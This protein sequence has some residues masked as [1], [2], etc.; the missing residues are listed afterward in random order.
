MQRDLLIQLLNRCRDAGFGLTVEGEIWSWNRAAEQLFGYAAKE[1]IGRPFADLLHAR[2]LMDEPIDEHYCRVAVRQGG[3]ASFDMQV[4]PRSGEPLWVSATVLVFEALRASPPVIVHLAHDIT[5]SKHREGLAEQLM[6]T[7]RRVLT[8][9]DEGGHFVPVTPLSEQERRILR[10]FFDGNSA[11]DV[12]EMLG[13]TPQTLRNH[14]HHI[15]QKLGTHNRLEAV[16][17][18]VRRKL[19]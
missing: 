8:V 14:L 6:E 10:G 1:A 12:T 19:I 9:T 5:V 7:A 4:K 3:V 13:I 2:G 11:R 18:A 17:H 16:T 15:N